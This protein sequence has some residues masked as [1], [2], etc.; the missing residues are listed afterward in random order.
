[1]AVEISGIS[2]CPSD[3]LITAAYIDYP[4]TGPVD[5]Y[6]FD[7]Y[8][9]VVAKETVAEVEFVHEGI[10]IACCELEV[11]RPDVA[12]KFRSSSRVGFWKAIGTVGLAPAF[13]IG[14]RIVFKG[15]RRREIA[16]IRGS[17]QLTSAFTPTMQ[18]ITVTSPGR[19]GST[20]LMRMLADHP[21]II[22]HERFPYEQRVCSYWMHFV[23]VL[24]TPVDTS[25]AESFEFWTD[26]KRLIPFPSFFLD[27]VFAGSVGA[28]VDRWYGSDQI[29][30]FA[31]VAQATVESFYREHAR[32]RKRA[33][34]SFFA[35]KFAPSGHIRSIIWQ[36]YPR[37]REIFLVRDPRDTLVSVRAFDNKRGRG[38]FAGQLVGTDEQL[39]GMVRDSI[40]DLTRLWKSRSKY[41]TL[42]HYEDLIHSPTEQ[43]RAMLDALELD[44]SANI[45]DA[46][47]QAGNESTADM[48]AHRTSPDVR[49]SI[50]RWKWDLEPRIQDMCDAAFDGLF[51]ELGG[52]PC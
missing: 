6:A 47:V 30:E 10:V 37:T 8:G 29:E 31:R 26:R 48:N 23:Q 13:T 44:S 7:A 22:V 16:E 2:V 12:K 49:S 32:G 17:Q 41:G 36:L 28:T 43:V 35:E 50:G 34:P 46:M 9:W 5:G 21:D 40:L 33:T 15:G 14:V 52:S 25:R 18:P 42:V 3:D 1:M 39:V 38:E 11:Q 27:P 51:D 45:V 19:S 20:L 24:A 4:R